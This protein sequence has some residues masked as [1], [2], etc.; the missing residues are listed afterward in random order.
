MYDRVRPFITGGGRFRLIE[1]FTTG[2]LPPRK[3]AVSRILPVSLYAAGRVRF[4]K[5]LSFVESVSLFN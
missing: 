3:Y 2:L 4:D 5:N 1:F